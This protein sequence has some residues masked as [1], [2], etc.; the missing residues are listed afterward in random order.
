MKIIFIANNELSTNCYFED[1]TNIEMKKK[2]RPLSIEGEKLALKLAKEEI[3]ND[4]ER[5][6]SDT[7]NGSI[8]SAKYLAERLNQDII[9]NKKVHDCKIGD[10]KGKTI[11]MLSYFQEHDF[12]FKLV[13]GESLTE[14]GN[15]V[16]SFIRK[17]IEEG[18][19]SIAVYLPKRCI[20][21]YLINHTETE[22]NL[23]ERLIL[24]YKDEVI[25]G[26]T[27][28]KLDVFILEYEGKELVNIK[29]YKM[30]N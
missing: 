14:C 24:T 8:A 19:E 1:E 20:M 21:A 2:Y 29:N 7:T 10:L 4:V 23:D 5:I 6:Y 26:N 18:Y 27:E 25:M 17:V 15:R 9:V 11:K 28:E 12:S 22:Y 16:S 3:F 13:G 30:E